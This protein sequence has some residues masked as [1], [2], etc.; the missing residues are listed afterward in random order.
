M[1]ISP[2]KILFFDFDETLANTEL[3]HTYARDA[4]LASFGVCIPDWG[5]YLGNSDLSIF[6]VMKERF[7]LDMDIPAAIDQKLQI[8]TDQAVKAG[9]QPYPE[10]DE[11]IRALP[12]RKF[13]ITNQRYEIV[14]FFL[15]KWGLD[16]YFEKIISLANQQISKADKIIEMGF[17]PCDCVLL[18]DISRNVQEAAAKGIRGI[19]VVDGKIDCE[20]IL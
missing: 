12:N 2:D 15:K 9:L 4:V 20:R 17:S 7:G 6:T 5:P 11:L 8:F 19:L 10:I 3:Y 1:N 18:D 16:D 13:V 14:S